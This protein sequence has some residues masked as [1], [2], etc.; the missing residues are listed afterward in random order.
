MITL[1]LFSEGEFDSSLGLLESS[2]ADIIKLGVLFE[3]LRVISSSSSIKRISSEPS[4]DLG[5][6]EDFLLSV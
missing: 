4:N 3:A 2:N 1:P 6:E 5:R